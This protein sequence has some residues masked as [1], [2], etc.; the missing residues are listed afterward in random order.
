MKKSSDTYLHGFS[1]EE[2]QRLRDQATF[3]EFAIYQNVDFSESYKILEV[4][5]GVGAQSEILLRRY[6][7][8]HL[9]GLDS[10]RAQL[11]AAN[12]TLNSLV[13]L[14]GRYDLLEM[15]AQKMAFRKN[16]F[17]GAFLCWILEHVPNPSKVLAE[18][19]RVLSPGSP[20]YI[21]EVL[22]SSFFLDPY[23]PNT[24]RYWMIFNDYQFANAGDPFV[25]AK[26]GNILVDL[27]FNDIKIDIKTWHFDKRNPERRKA[28]ILYWTNLLMSAKN[29]LLEKK[30]VDEK[31][32][33]GMQKELKAVANNPDAVF[34]YSFAQ[35]FATV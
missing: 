23:A 10:S 19:K 8:I 30:L 22:N 7:H 13:Q 14:K 11:N 24:W 21:T 28:T 20:I 5:C 15:N 2:Q 26:L 16:T 17:D 25:G 33:S 1:K 18:V 32:V 31:L 29:L 3:A 27:K 12:H 4:G 35:A 6:P 9:T 34:F